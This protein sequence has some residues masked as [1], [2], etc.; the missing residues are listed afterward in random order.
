MYLQIDRNIILFDLVMFFFQKKWF[1]SGYFRQSENGFLV[2]ILERPTGFSTL[3]KLGNPVY[4]V[5]A[6]LSKVRD[7]HYRLV[8][9]DISRSRK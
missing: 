3:K 9:G 2:V 8:G 5:I 1:F 4:V 7:G 6:R